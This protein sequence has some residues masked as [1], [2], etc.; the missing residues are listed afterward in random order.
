MEYKYCVL[1]ADSTGL[2]WLNA[3]T[4]A[5]ATK[6]FLETRE[7]KDNEYTMWLFYEGYSLIYKSTN[8]TPLTNTL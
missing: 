4:E 8:R 7:G 5:E 6:K 3:E 2:K 1:I